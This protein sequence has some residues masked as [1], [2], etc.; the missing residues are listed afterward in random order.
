[1]ILPALAL[2]YGVAWAAQGSAPFFAS[3]ACPDPSPSGS[4]G[5]PSGS[6][7]STAPSEGDEG[8]SLSFGFQP[9]PLEPHAAVGWNFSVTNVSQDVVAM[10][11]PSGQDGD[12]VLSQNGEERYRWSAGRFFTQAL[13]TVELA[14]SEAY[15]FT[16]EDTLAVEPGSYDL[17]AT[18]AGEPPPTPVVRTVTVGEPSAT[19]A[20]ESP[21]PSGSP[22][23]TDTTSPGPTSSS[24]PEPTESATPSADGTA[25]PSPLFPFAAPLVA[26]GARGAWRRRRYLTTIALVLALLAVPFGQVRAQEDGSGG[27]NVVLVFNESDDRVAARAG[28]VL[29][30]ASGPTAVPENLASAKAS[31]TDCRTVAVAFQAVLIISDPDV[32][33]PRNA[34]AAV[35]GGCVRC[36]T[37]AYAWQYVVTTGG[38]V[39]VT[40]EGE[41]TI[42]DLRAE[43]SSLAASDLPFP[44]L[45]DE[46]DQVAAAFR[47][48]V[49]EEVERVGGSGV[50]ER[51]LDVEADPC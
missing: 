39:R 9:D 10:T 29:G 34:A 6:S 44:E 41:Q 7:P 15:H 32:A 5:S 45:V 40:P 35:N 12:V 26:G 21:A 33:S 19:G 49:D 18:V 20:S 28:L 2:A 46:L 16:L 30:R 31:C 51:A 37:F 47:A 11:F 27:K 4:A 24:S 3:S 42:A 22:E 43:A 1:V 38:P 50:S 14:P 8:L 25:S 23:P 13:R 17:T 48:V 36:E